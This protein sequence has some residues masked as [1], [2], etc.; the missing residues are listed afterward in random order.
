MTQS[1]SPNKPSYAALRPA[2]RDDAYKRPASATP[3]PSQ[4]K[5]PRDGTKTP[6]PRLETVG[7]M[8]KGLL[9]KGPSWLETECWVWG[10]NKHDKRQ[11]VLQKTRVINA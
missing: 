6:I 4:F 9:A 3:C 5:C 11:R 2:K 1:F 7:G 8:K 10:Q